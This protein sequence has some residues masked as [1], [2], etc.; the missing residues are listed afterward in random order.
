MEFTIASSISPTSVSMTSIARLSL[1]RCIH[2]LESMIRFNGLSAM[3]QFVLSIKCSLSSFRDDHPSNVPRFES[4]A[5]FRFIEANRSDNIA[6]WLF[7]QCPNDLV[8]PASA[9]RYVIFWWIPLQNSKIIAQ[10]FWRIV[11]FFIFFYFSFLR[12][13]AEIELLARSLGSH[14]NSLL[15]VNDVSQD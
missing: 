5:I 1:C 2:Q 8:V 4:N 6:L 3:N 10:A 9:Q 7:R 11:V 14:N 15:I 12:V 13:W